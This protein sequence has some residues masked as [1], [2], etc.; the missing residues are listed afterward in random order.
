MTGKPTASER[1][2]PWL[3]LLGGIILVSFAGQLLLLKFGSGMARWSYDLP[4]LWRQQSVPEDLVMVYLDSKIKSRLGQPTDQPLDRRFYTQLLERLTA[5]GARLVIFDI[6]FDS[7]QTNSNTDAA[8]AEAIRKHGKV[9]LVGDYIKQW[10]GDYATSSPLPP[11]ASLKDAA[12]GWGLANV[13][14][15]HDLEVRVLSTGT[16][17]IPSADWIAASLLDGEATRRSKSRLMKRWVNYFCEP[18]ALRAVNL[19]QALEPNGLTAGF[20]HEKIV[21]VG[22]RRE[23]GVAG[24][25]RDEFRTPYSYSL[26]KGSL[27][28]EPMAPGAAIHA[29]TLL[30]LIRGDW[31]TRLSFA[32][33][34]TL[35]LIWGIFISAV[36]LRLRPWPATLVAPV[37]FCTFALLSIY[38]HGRWHLWFSWLVPA[39]VQTSVALVWSVGFQ[40]LVESRRRRKL[41]NAFA[42]YLSPYMA[43][44]IANSKFDLSLGGTEVEATIMFTD[45]KGFTNMSETLPTAEVSHILTSYFNATTRAILEQDGTII[46]YIGDA[47]LA[48]WGA[49]MPEPRHAERAVRAAWGMIQA[50]Q[51]EIAGRSLQTRIG[52]NT[53]KV[54]A[55]NLG[56]DFRFNYDAIGDTTN[57]ASRLESLNKYFAT[58]LLVGEATRKQLSG[59]FRTRHLGRFLMAGKTQPVSVY[60]VLGVDLLSIEDPPWVASF[61]AAVRNYTGCKLD[62]AEQLFREVIKLRSGQDGPSEFYLNQISAARLGAPSAEGPWDGVVVIQSK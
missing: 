35:V 29:F 10:Q 45:L 2:I 51:K 3:G 7:S 55:G 43:D 26:R 24:A 41:R 62:E 4:F 49:P 42:A 48:I 59:Q 17:D 20:F 50:G 23:G 18:T 61:D 1:K 60:E 6:L 33:E 53:G 28:E 14:A 54:L 46:K 21:V 27:R 12:A 5:E 39:G 13:V 16:E 36:L 38:V 22:S 19:D 47:V 56:S 32:W 34:S 37:V 58:D 31:L 15:D 44:Q 40:Y 25:E 11:I 57:T 9:V 30:N 52:I 8:F